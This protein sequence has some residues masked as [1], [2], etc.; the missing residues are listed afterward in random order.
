MVLA[1]VLGILATN[2]SMLSQAVLNSSIFI[3][4]N[5]KEIGLNR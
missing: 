3:Y 1:F 4:Q 5:E 2:L